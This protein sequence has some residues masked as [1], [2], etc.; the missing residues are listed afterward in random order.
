MVPVGHGGR[1]LRRRLPSD[2]TRGPVAAFAAHAGVGP[3]LP[4]G[5]LFAFWQSA[6][7][8]FGQWHARGGVQAL[9]DALVL[10]LEKLGGAIRCSARVERIDAPGGRITG[11]VVKGVSESPPRR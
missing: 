9:A 4:G 3:T 6:Y 2:L 11:V 8:L 7:H 5:A 10:R 1:V